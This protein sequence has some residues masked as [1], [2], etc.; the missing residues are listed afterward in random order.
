[1]SS[2]E[3]SYLTAERAIESVPALKQALNDLPVG[4]RDE[5]VGDLVEEAI[6]VASDGETSRLVR[7]MNSILVTARLHRNP[8][9]MKALGEDEA[10]PKREPY[11]ADVAPLFA[12]ARGSRFPSP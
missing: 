2:E 6:R 7:K 11:D 3:A 4:Q 5:I 1:M 9:Y 12:E 8:R 10:T